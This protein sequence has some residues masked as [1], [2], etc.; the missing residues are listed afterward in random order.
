MVFFKADIGMSS[1]LVLKSMCFMN[2]NK[3][4]CQVLCLTC[5]L[6]TQHKDGRIQ[7]SSLKAGGQAN[8]TVP[9]HAVCT[10]SSSASRLTVVVSWCRFLE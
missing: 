4:F 9:T 8:V 3:S 10:S 1:C 2:M 5:R 7:S 6:Q